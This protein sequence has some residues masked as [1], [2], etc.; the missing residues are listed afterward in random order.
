M[1]VRIKNT[2]I[3]TEDIVA[4]QRNG[5]GLEFYMKHSPIGAHIEIAFDNYVAPDKVLGK[6]AEGIIAEE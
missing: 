5:N 2:I 4:V 3:N 1:L 6:L